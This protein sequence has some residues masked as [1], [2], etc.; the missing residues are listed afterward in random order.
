M[1]VSHHSPLSAHHSYFKLLLQARNPDASQNFKAILT[2]SAQCVCVCMALHALFL[3]VFFRR[4][5]SLGRCEV[6]ALIIDAF[7][8]LRNIF[9][10]KRLR[11]RCK[12]CQIL[13]SLGAQMYV[14]SAV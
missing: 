2:E 13:S 1:P 9:L 8:L 10:F 3:K 4:P 12:Y 6:G 11:P 5:V 14:K 7:T